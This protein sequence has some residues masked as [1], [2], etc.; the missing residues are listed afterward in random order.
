LRQATPPGPKRPQFRQANQ[1]LT[2]YV[3][4]LLRRWR[5]GCGDSAQLRR[6]IQALGYTHSA[7]TVSRFVTQL[8]RAGEAG[9]P[10]E[11]L[12]PFTRPQGPSAR[13]VSFVI[14]RP[15]AQRSTEE[16]TYLDQLC[17]SHT[18]IAGA[19]ALTQAFLTIVRERRGAD[20]DALDGGRNPERQRRIDA[21]CARTAGRPAGRSGWADFGMQ[22]WGHGRP[23]SSAEIDHVPG[24]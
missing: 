18:I 9:R 12:S 22:Q 13:A 24:V 21:L 20:L 1:V 3:P 16:Q 11:Q 4:Y 23:Q 19:N 5:E 14:V 2:P 10:P 8:R 15:A 6:E 17:Q 7:R